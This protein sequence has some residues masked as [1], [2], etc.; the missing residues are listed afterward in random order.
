MLNFQNFV[1]TCV[2]WSFLLVFCSKS[3]LPQH[4][5]FPEFC[6]NMC[7][8]TFLNKKVFFS[9]ISFHAILL[10]KHVFLEIFRKKIK[11]QNFDLLWR[12]L[13]FKKQNVP[14]KHV[15][16]YIFSLP[17]WGFHFFLFLR[18]FLTID[19]QWDFDQNRYLFK[20]KTVFCSSLFC[21]SPKFLRPAAHELRWAICLQKIGIIEN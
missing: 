6:Q 11:K 20:E 15:F 5:K 17:W 3:K 12:K 4:A 21:T 8:F 10:Y 7:F 18:F 1:K 13:F 9:R 19:S 14:K 16:Q 2:F